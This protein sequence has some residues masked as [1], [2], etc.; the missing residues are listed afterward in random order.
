M[1]NSVQTEKSRINE[2]TKGK[3]RLCDK[4]DQ[5][6]NFTNIFCSEGEEI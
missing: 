4:S 5:R 3:R 6:E 1:I 2:E